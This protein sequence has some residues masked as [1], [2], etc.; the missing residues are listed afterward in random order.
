MLDMSWSTGAGRAVD[1]GGV[2]QHQALQR[3]GPGLHELVPPGGQAVRLDL[4]TPGVKVRAADPR[5]RQAPPRLRYGALN[6]MCQWVPLQNG[7]LGEPPQRHR[8]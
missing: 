2:E 1:L 6:P 4:E 5:R 3:V 8:V 7:L